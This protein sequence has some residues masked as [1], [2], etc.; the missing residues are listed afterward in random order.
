MLTYLFVYSIGIL[1]GWIT[2]HYLGQ[3]SQPKNYLSQET[4]KHAKKV[5]TVPIILNS[6]NNNDLDLIMDVLVFVDENHPIFLNLENETNFSQINEYLM[7][8]LLKLDKVHGSHFRNVR[9]SLVLQIQ[10]YQNDL[11]KLLIK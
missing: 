6:P 3:K 7:Q 4:D 9:K 8:N 2:I 1:T 10:Q 11:D 5:K